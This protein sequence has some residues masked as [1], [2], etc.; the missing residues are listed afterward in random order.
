MQLDPRIGAL[1]SGRYYAFPNGYDKPEVIGS[2]AEVE[3]VLG[4]RS[5]AVTTEMAQDVDVGALKPVIRTWNVTLRFKFPAWDEVD[6]LV[7]AGIE[8]S[9]KS[10]AI[11]IARKGAHE[12]GITIG[13]GR[14]VFSAT[15]S[16]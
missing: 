10:E 3:M 6:G 13:R 9:S 5:E 16:G 2:L 15:E 11:K 8:A 4:I 1:S 7:F 12:D 14:Y